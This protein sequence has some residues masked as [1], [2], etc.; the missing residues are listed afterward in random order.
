MFDRLKVNYC[1]YQL[2]AI[3]YQLQA[4]V[5]NRMKT[6]SVNLFLVGAV[7][8]LV[9]IAPADVLGQSAATAKPPAR[10]R[11]PQAIGVAEATELANGWAYLAEGRPDQALIRAE[12]LLAADG[13]HAAALVL[14]VEAEIARGGTDAALIRY[15]RWLGQRTIEEPAV[16]RSLAL[17]VLRELGARKSDPASLDA[18]RVLAGN[19]DRAAAAQLAQGSG[20]ANA[21]DTRQRASSGDERAVK[22]LAAQLGRD[23]GNA[24]GTIEALGAS[25]SRNAVA[26]LTA[27]LQ[28]PSPEIRG[29][30]ADALG[31]LGA[32]Y[33]VAESLRPLLKDPVSF[34]R[35]K[36]AGALYGVGDM[37][38]IAILT[39]LASADS[40]VSR[41][42]AA[43]AMASQPGSEWQESLRR[44]TTAPEPE[45]R[46]GAAKLLAPYDPETALRVLEAAASDPTPAIRDMAAEVLAEVQAG[47]LRA[48]R[49]L[50]KSPSP[51]TKIRA[52]GR[53]LALLR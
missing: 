28:H 18:L 4:E 41:L 30:A 24:L 47:D 40:S 3:S 27:R 32:K 49:G 21:A 31:R 36:A 29:A 48:L 8:V 45:V 7:T 10:P 39:D 53:I 14:A 16:V 52:A 23:G 34:V 5:N 20:T 25:G 2:S 22:A 33:D 35:V 15:E 19:G 1:S 43:Q 9:G 13:R 42:M 44:L 26:P 50:L 17:G 37:S 6:S 46:V 38:G 11:A 51:R 12:R